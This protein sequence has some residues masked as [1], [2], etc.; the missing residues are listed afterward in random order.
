[1]SNT[2]Q[3][4][5]GWPQARNRWEASLQQ[6]GSTLLPGSP[7]RKAA[8][9][10]VLCGGL[11]GGFLTVASWSAAL[12]VQFG[13]LVAAAALFGVVM[14]LLWARPRAGV[15]VSW[16]GVEVPYGSA[17]K[18]PVHL[19]WPEIH[20]V[21]LATEEDSSTSIRLHLQPGAAPRLGLPRGTVKGA[22]AQHSGWVELPQALQGD[23]RQFA[24]WL[25][26]VHQRS[27]LPPPFDSHPI[28]R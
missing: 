16:Q 15:R 12:V 17:R 18:P 9:S 19:P 28:Q 26:S 22:S 27:A 8:A 6:T 10:C 7:A 23:R 3:P 11:F 20:W 5:Q 21:E 25:Q 2:A 13:Y 14:F 4:W 24:A 1:M